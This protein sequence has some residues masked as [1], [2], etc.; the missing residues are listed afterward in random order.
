[1]IKRIS[2]FIMIAVLFLC[3]IGFS[4]C[5]KDKEQETQPTIAFETT[6]YEVWVG[7]TITL[8]PTV[9]GVENPKVEY[10][11]DKEGVIS[12]V[13]TGTYTA[14]AAGNVTITATVK[15]VTLTASATIL[16]TVKEKVL[17]SSITVSGETTMTEGD[18]QTLTAT[19]E[20]TDANDKTFK[21]STSNAK[22]GT[23]SESGVVTA[24]KAGTVTFT[25][26]A[27]DGSGKTGTIKV[28]VKEKQVLATSIEFTL[29]DKYFVGDEVKL[30]AKV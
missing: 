16:V 18:T 6:A 22:I 8:N 10:S 19:V 23:I 5:K 24:V 14:L 21:W 11:L 29:E 4:A 20:P 13:N 30:E 26:T 12:S 7:E 28:I 27:N 17:V 9:T 15:N 25:A 2:K 3:I 1:M